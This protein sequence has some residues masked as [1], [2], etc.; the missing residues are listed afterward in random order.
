MTT[1]LNPKQILELIP[2][3]EPFRFVDEILEVNELKIVGAYTF[4]K[5]ANFYEGHFPGNPVT[6]GVILLEAMCQLDKLPPATYPREQWQVAKALF[7]VLSR[8]LAE[9]QIVF[10]QRGAEYPGV[11]HTMTRSD[12]TERGTVCLKRK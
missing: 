8:A 5:T 7:R 6:P 1:I 12:S 11:L 9:L 3:K 4:H 10:A 2:Q